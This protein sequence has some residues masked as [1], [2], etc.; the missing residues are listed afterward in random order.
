LPK[1]VIKFDGIGQN[2]FYLL[3]SFWSHVSR[4]EVV[5]IFIR[6]PA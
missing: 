2:C 1:R 6:S 5:K 3:P 4:G